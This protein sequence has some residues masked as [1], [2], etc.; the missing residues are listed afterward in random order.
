LMRSSSDSSPNACGQRKSNA[1]RRKHVF[2]TQF[3][4]KCTPVTTR[5]RLVFAKIFEAQRAA[6]CLFSLW[7][8][9]QNLLERGSLVSFSEPTERK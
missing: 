1:M 7:Q 2:M 3:Y 8:F 9:W 4:T 5:L 6:F